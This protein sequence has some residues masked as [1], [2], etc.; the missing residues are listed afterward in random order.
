MMQSNKITTFSQMSRHLELEE[1]RKRF[2]TGITV[3]WLSLVSEEHL[4]PNGSD[5]AKHIKVEKLSL[6]IRRKMCS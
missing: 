5:I 4:G 6:E 2:Q 3:M 1:E